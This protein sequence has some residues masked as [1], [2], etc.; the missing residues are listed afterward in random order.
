M[1]E[2]SFASG[3]MAPSNSMVDTTPLAT[4]LLSA[5][6]ETRQFAARGIAISLQ[7]PALTLQP[8]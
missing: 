1:Q 6:I 5:K 8:T 3:S 4:V 2:A 7:C